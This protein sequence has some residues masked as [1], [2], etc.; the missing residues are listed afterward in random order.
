MASKKDLNF[1]DCLH[2]NSRTGEVDSINNYELAR[3]ILNYVP[4]ICVVETRE[5]LTYINGRYMSNGEE[6]IHRVLVEYLAPYVKKGGNTAYSDH[7][8]REVLS[9]IRGMSYRYIRQFDE[10]LDI[11]NLK[12]GL[13]NIKTLELSPHTPD[14]PTRIQHPVEYDPK[15]TCPNAEKVIRTIFKEKDHNKILEFIGYCLYRGYPVQ[16]AF[17]LLGPGGTGKTHFIDIVCRMIGDQNVSSASVHDLENDRFASAELF[18]K[19]VNQYDDMEQSTLANINMLKMLTSDKARVRAQRKN[20]HPFDFVNFAKMVFSTNRL[21]R[22]NDDTTGFFR[23]IEIFHMDHVFREGD[24]DPELLE[25]A[26]RPE[27]LSGLLN[28]VIPYL[29]NLLERRKFSNA[30]SIEDMRT[31]YL[32]AS[33]PITSFVEGYIEEDP[34]SDTVKSDVYEAY[35]IFCMLN[36]IDIPS[37]TKFFRDFTKAVPWQRI[38][39]VKNINGNNKAVWLHM[40]LRDVIGVDD[41]TSE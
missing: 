2:I 33:D 41:G 4:V 10:D 16:K 21:P 5:V 36:K 38:S 32:T 25:R 30:F 7:L 35:T 23:R 9:I 15:A 26:I 31:Q 24:Q 29:W 18:Q 34:D 40:K 3:W 37:K 8:F 39:S 27:E 19:C 28:L 22:V 17:I 1:K 20:Q 13:L 6:F 14:Y 11:I 12:N